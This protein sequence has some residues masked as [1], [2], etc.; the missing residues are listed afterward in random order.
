MNY[1]ILNSSNLNEPIK[2]SYIDDNQINNNNQNINN[3]NILLNN[4]FDREFHN[5]KFSDDTKIN[6]YSINIIKK[7]K[8]RFINTINGY[9]KKKQ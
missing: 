6:K 1:I 7:R 8:K 5:R 4:T 3:N 2:T 9:S